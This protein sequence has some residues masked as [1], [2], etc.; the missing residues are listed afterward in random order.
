MTKRVDLAAALA[1]AI[2]AQ[3][4]DAN[5]RECCGLLEGMRGDGGFRVMALH[6]VRNLSSDAAHFA[7]DPQDQFAAQRAAR[8]NGRFIIG[9]Y[10]SHPGGPAQPSAADRAGAGEEDFLWLIAG[11]EDLRAFVYLDGEFFGADCVTSS[12]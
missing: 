8:A 11:D 7:M 4:Q 2:R 5:P 10:H 12:G 1:E 3:A 9:C 6:P